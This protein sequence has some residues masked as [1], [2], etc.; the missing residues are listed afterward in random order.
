M[1][2]IG[3][4]LTRMHPQTSYLIEPWSLRGFETVHGSVTFTIG[5]LILISGLLTTFEFALKAS[6]S[7]GIAALMGVGAVGVAVIYGTDDRAMGGGIIGWALA[8]LAGYILR[9]A[10][11]KALPTILPELSSTIHSLIGLG[12]FLVGALVSNLILFGGERTAKPWVWVAIAAAL[13]VGL[14]IVGQHA[15]LSANRMLIFATVGGWLTI[16]LSAAAARMNLLDAQLEESLLQGQYKDTQITSGYFVALLG[17]L[18][19]FVAA[20]SLWAK[21]R[22]VIINRLR[23][24]RQRE[25]AEASAAEIQAALELAQKHQREARTGQ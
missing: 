21:R 12:V 6:Y 19:V 5:A 13:A 16:A 7:R 8:I 20:V 2:S 17:M 10:V 24:E 15:E 18:I 9:K 3:W 25:A 4:E 22:D 23:A 11:A 1:G 14:A